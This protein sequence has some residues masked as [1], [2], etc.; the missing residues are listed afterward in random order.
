V[1]KRN[2][3][4]VTRGHSTMHLKRRAGVL[5]LVLLLILPVIGLNA[6][7]SSAQL[8]DLSTATCSHPDLTYNAKRQKIE[9]L[10]VNGKNV[11]L[12]DE[13]IEIVSIEFN[14]KKVTR[15]HNP[16]KYKVIFRAKGSSKRFK[17]QKEVIIIVKKSTAAKIAKS[18]KKKIQKKTYKV[19]K[20]GKKKA[21]LNLKYQVITKKSKKGI[22]Y[23]ITGKNKKYFKIDKNGVITLSKKAKVKAGN[24]EVTVKTVRKE[25]KHYFRKVSKPIKIKIKVTD[26]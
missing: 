2:R 22:T 25:S 18:D 12:K 26:K 1:A 16:G 19:S 10:N 14:G 11:N 23:K 20:N 13:G 5:F 4:K 6:A 8:I 7:E 15:I 24:Y 17:G 9:S 21:K 3:L